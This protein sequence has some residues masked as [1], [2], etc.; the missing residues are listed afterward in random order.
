MTLT[1]EEKKGISTELDRARAALSGGNDGK[2][3][4]CAR[5][6]AGIALQAYYRA[7]T[8][9]PWSGDAQSLL[10]R[11]STNPEIP[12]DARDASLRLTT[13]ITQK[14]SAPFSTDPIADAL[15][16]ISNVETPGS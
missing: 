5:R 12:P 13:S 7:I 14:D 9:V 2:V 8:G 1:D 3:R 15:A 10:L 6:A 4:V 16:I 11:A